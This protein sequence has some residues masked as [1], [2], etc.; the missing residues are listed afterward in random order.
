MLDARSMRVAGPITEYQESS[1]D[2]QLQRFD[3]KG[4]SQSI[5]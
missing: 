1:D 2:N 3:C 4:L 5:F